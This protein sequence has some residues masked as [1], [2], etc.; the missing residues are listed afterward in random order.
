VGWWAQSNGEDI[1]LPGGITKATVRGDLFRIREWYGW[2]GKPNEGVRMIASDIAKGIVE[3][4]LRWGFRTS[5]S[6][7]C[8]VKSGVADAQIFSAENGNCINTDMK[9]RVKL[10]DGYSYPGIEWVACDKRP[11]SRIT[12]WDQ[13]RRMLKNAHPAKHGPREYPGLFIWDVCDQFQRTVPVLPRDEK[14]PDD[15]N[16]DAEDHTAD[17]IRYKVRS[18]GIIPTS[19]RT[20]GMY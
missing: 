12:G 8:R 2:T 13:M 1:I 10:D 20:I 5:K 6:N 3:R 14:E 9:V 15:V 11:G 17:E 19:G 18:I 4:E 7:W 16:T